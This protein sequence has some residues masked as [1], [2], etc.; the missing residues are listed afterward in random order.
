MNSLLTVNHHIND[1]NNFV[2]SVRQSNNTYYMFVS[3]PQPWA[4][5]SGGNDD[6]AV[7]VVNGSITQ[8]ELNT[9]DDLLYGKKIDPSDIVHVA[10]RYNW[11]SNTVYSQYDQ[12]DENLYTTNFYVVTDQYSVFKCIDNAGGIPSTVKPTLTTTSGTFKTGDGYTWK[13][14]Y[15]IDAT[16]NSKFTT[17]NYIP[18]LSNTAVTSN[19]VPGT[20]DVIRIANGGNSYSVYESGFIDS[21]VDTLTIKLPDNSS[22]ADGHYV[23]SSIYLKSGF[24]AG[25]VREII[26]YTGATRSTTI[27]LPIDTF[28]RLDFANSTSITGGSVGETVRQEFDSI[29]F[30]SSVGYFSAGANIVQTTTGVGATVL[31][32]NSN[33]LRVSR[34]NKNQNFTPGLAIRDLSD[35]GALQTDKV[36]I[37]NASTLGLGIV[38]TSGTGYTGN[39]TVTIT[40]N[41]GIGGVANAQANSTGKIIA[42]NIANTGTGYTSEPQVTVA[43]PTAQTFNANTDV[44]G[45]TD[46]GSNNVIA[47][48]TADVFV[49]G[50]QIRYTTSAGNTAIGGLSNNTVYFIQF[51]NSTVV[52]LSNSSNTSSGNRIE[53]TPGATETG[54]TLQGIRA[55]G[56]VVPTSMFAVNAAAAPILST[57]YSVGDFIR[58]GENANN[59]V[60]RINT[61]NSTILIVGVPFTSTLTSANTFKISTALIPSTIT[62]SIASGVISNTNLDSIRLTI[63]NTSVP[64]A[65]FILGERVDFVTTANASLN[66]NGTVAFSNSTTLFIAGINGTWYSGQRVRGNSSDLFADIVTLDS[67]PNVTVKN[68]IG[69]F[70]LGDPVDFRSTTGSNTG[71]ATLTSVVNLSRGAIEYEIA[72]TVRI[73]GDG[74]GAIAVSTVNGTIGFANAI[75]SINVIAPGSGYTQ[76]NVTVFSNTLYGSGA[77]VTPVISPLEGHGADTITQL[78]ARYAGMTVKFDT[79]SNESWYYPSNISF[80]RVGI[81]KNP[82]FANLTVQTVDYTSV[83]LNIAN[84]VG[85]WIADEY[86]FQS[87]T[88]AIARVISSNSTV[89]KVYDTSGTF[90]Q[91]NTIAGLT[92]GT[93][94]DVIGV[95][96]VRFVEGERVVQDNTNASGTVFVYVGNTTIYMSNVAGQLSNNQVIR[97]QQ[98]NAV[99]TVSSIFSA[100]D[101]RD[102]STTFAKKF[103][104][105]SRLT[106]NSN[107]GSF[108][109]MEFITQAQT[110]AT[111]RVILTGYDLDLQV[112]SV[113]GSFS[114][115]DTITNSN[116]SANAKCVFANSS[117]L[118][119][120]AVSNTSLFPANSVINNGLGSS[121]TVQRNYQVILVSDVSRS[122]KFESGISL[123][124]GQNTGSVATL[125]LVSNPDLTRESGKVLYIENS[126][127]VITRSLNST[128]ELRLIIRF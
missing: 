47:L 7:Q 20:I 13:Y 17:A 56:R 72:P 83:D 128:E 9:F 118:R 14:M 49:I 67:N 120:T 15:T 34:F 100:D 88:N 114:I 115:G 125:S 2:E 41:S 3:R 37:S 96:S 23:R 117:Y 110:N 113:S 53:L 22:S 30:T 74:Q 109:N 92:S 8:I 99:A 39:A 87:T 5:S 69:T 35:T 107:T 63:A 6:T 121:A 1:V 112:N 71:I 28:T 16:S 91:S 54:H 64:G 85:V 18:I 66:A 27:N 86:V 79:S 10:P 61:V 78:G 108:A 90:A 103:N 126:N 119:L 77:V 21:I 44:T 57:E 81:M 62:T 36:N 116:T 46:E 11:V 12:N 123:V 98:S 122:S 70:S 95:T 84:Q 82:R 65:S 31:S 73:I 105:T 60:R 40:S 76:A 124:T 38:L 106:I 58:V 51:S 93:S 102:L 4:N 104:Q 45:G 97:G 29:N 89:L 25:Q 59:N 19:A 111:G 33:T 68:P 32:A 55:T 48:A 127:N 50:D 75:S 94:A 52:A 42:I 26:G 24:G 101:S 43:A 80:R